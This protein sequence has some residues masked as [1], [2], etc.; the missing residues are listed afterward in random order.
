MIKNNEQNKKKSQK[1]V[2]NHYLDNQFYTGFTKE[3][4]ISL[5]KVREIGLKYWSLSGNVVSAKEN[6][7]VSFESSL[8]RDYI[9]HLEFDN[10]VNRYSEQPIKIY[11]KIKER[12]TFYV[13]DFYVEY[14]EGAKKEIIE[15]KYE[16]DLK[17][18]KS[19]YKAKFKVAE[20]FCLANNMCFK[21]ITE[22]SIR[23]DRLWNI[24]FL[25]KYRHPNSEINYE[26][27][28]L[29]VSKVKENKEI[30]P[31]K[32]INDSGLN[33]DI[34]GIVLYT[35]WYC[36]ANNF[37]SVDLDRKLCMNSKLK[38]GDIL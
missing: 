32:L 16:E 18:N 6:R 31:I 33:K 26:Y 4:R 7:F 11:Y 25:L 23:T 8:E 10:N 38:I 17:V 1:K 3:I 28:S 12:R 30:T 22:K 20:D 29:I 35:L 15:I 24:K 19:K 27:V 9:Y 37:I 2:I 34:R 5:K 21:V 13:P 36:I 14:I